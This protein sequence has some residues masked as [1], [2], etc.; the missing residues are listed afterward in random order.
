MTGSCNVEAVLELRAEVSVLAEPRCTGPILAKMAKR[1]GRAVTGRQVDGELLSAV[2]FDPRV[3]CEIVPDLRKWPQWM[4]R[5]AGARIQLSERHACVVWA[6]YG[7][8]QPKVTE[9]AELQDVTQE[10]LLQ[11]RRFGEIPVVMAGD[12]NALA[13]DCTSLVRLSRD[14]WADLGG[15]PTCLAAQSVQGR[16][17]DLTFANKEYQS[18]V[19]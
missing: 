5:V 13:K 19:L 2:I 18:C 3:G 6:I 9:L 17:I 8:D 14:G 15:E 16:R 1:W 12:F 10:L 11:A 4:C 7:K